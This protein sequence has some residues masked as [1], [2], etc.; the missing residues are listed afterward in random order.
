MDLFSEREPLPKNFREELSALESYV[1]GI[2]MEESQDFLTALIY[3]RRCA[4]NR[5]AI[6]APTEDAQKAIARIAKEHPDIMTNTE[7]ALILR[8]D[9]MERKI[10]YQSRYGNRR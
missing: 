1:T 3:Y 5:G 7:A 2:K 8:L 9:R 10:L 4:G 6:N